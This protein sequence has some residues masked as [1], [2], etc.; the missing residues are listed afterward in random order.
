MADY[1]SL[2]VY[3]VVTGPG[4]TYNQYIGSVAGSQYNLDGVSIKNLLLDKNKEYF[5]EIRNNNYWS[6]GTDYDLTINPVVT[7]PDPEYPAIEEINTP[8]DF[9]IDGQWVGFGDQTDIKKF[10]VDANGGNYEFT[11]NRPAVGDKE[12]VLVQVCQDMGKDYWGNQI[13]RYVYSNYFY[14]GSEE[15]STGNLFLANGNYHIIINAVNAPWG[16]NSHYSVSGK[17]YEIT[18][19]MINDK[20]NNSCYKKICHTSSII[21]FLF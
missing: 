1:M 18:D 20:Y 14:A 17:G 13:Y 9:K 19:D 16:Y 3:E 4:Y 15:L 7:F 8:A 10:S 5:V 12:I 21:P 2:Y 11:F 6:T